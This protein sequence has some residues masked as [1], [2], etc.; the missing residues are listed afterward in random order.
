MIELTSKKLKKQKLFSIFALIGGLA[1]MM[2]G[3]GA[4]R[5]ALVVDSTLL[6]SLFAV[7]GLVG[8]IIAVAGALL[9]IATRVSTWWN[10]G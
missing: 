9:G 3:F 6:A 5:T 2:V 4:I 7:M 10:H 8:L 1:L